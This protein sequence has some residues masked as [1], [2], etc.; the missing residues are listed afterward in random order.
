MS[1][2]I[3][4]TVRRGAV[5]ARSRAAFPTRTEPSS[6][7]ETT[8]GTKIR[9]PLASRTISGFPFTTRATREFVVPRSIPTMRSVMRDVLAAEFLPQ[10]L[11]EVRDVLERVELEPDLRDVAGADDLRSIP[12]MRSVMRDVL[13]AEFLPQLLDEV[14]D[15][16]ER[17]ELEPDLRDV[18]GAEELG[19]AR[20]GVGLALLERGEERLEARRVALLEEL[21]VLEH[22]GEEPGRR[23]LVLVGGLAAQELEEVLGPLVAVLERRVG[24]VHGGRE[25]ERALLAPRER[26]V[27]LDGELLVGVEL[28]REVEERLLERG[29]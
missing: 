14:R 25:R 29:V 7:K 5:A 4:W 28:P 8:E 12:T 11:D 3:E 19:E 20:P 22:L 15:V 23:A 24:L 27:R 1:L 26:L 13:A 6:R 21:A 17:V 10:L 18:A 2:L 9:S 16:L